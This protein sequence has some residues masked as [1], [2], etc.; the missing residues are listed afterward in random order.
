MIMDSD[1]K[2]TSLPPLTPRLLFHPMEPL[3]QAALARQLQISRSTV[4]HVLNGRGHLIRPEV[5]KRIEDAVQASGYHRNG[6]VRALKS[7]RSHVVGIIV[8]EI[9][10]SFFSEI[11][12]A[13]EK[14][15][16]RQGL[17][18]F[19]AQSHSEPAQIQSSI[20][21]MREYRV[22]GILITPS[23]SSANPEL[24]RRLLQQRFPFV[25]VDSPILDVPAPFVGN[26]N[27]QIG[28]LATEHL[29]SLGHREIACIRGYSEG[30]ASSQRM[31]GYRQALKDAGVL[32][33]ERLVV[34]G[35]FQFESGGQ[36]VRTLLAS[37][38][39]F[40]AIVASSDHAALGAI[41]ELQAAGRRVPEDVSVVG[42]ANVD[43]AAMS[44][45]PLTT[46]DQKPDELGSR[47]MSELIR[48]IENPEVPGVNILI[49]SSLLVRRSTRAPD[50]A[51]D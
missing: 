26:D 17:Q 32:F 41:Q 39:R 3:S 11:I 28:R 38:Q 29:L 31:E 20:L 18:C 50:G 30:L 47:A 4:S 45:P 24:Y 9:G 12:R 14:E 25:L 43:I 51:G 1:H 49:E 42:C 35:G 16:Q 33:N 44:T 40:S 10:R 48:R 36:A 21:T 27:V 46:V 5:R 34:G 2:I 6:L 8:P 19:L 13:A 23:S 37:G 22:D 15:A 7:K